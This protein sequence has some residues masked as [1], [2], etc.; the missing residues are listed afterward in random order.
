M[1]DINLLNNFFILNGRHNLFSNDLHLFVDRHLYVLDDFNFNDSLLN[2]RYIHLLDDFFNF[3]DFNNPINNPFD[4]LWNL[5]YLLNNSRYYNNF[6][7]NF[8]N[9]NNFRHFD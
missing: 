3:L 4:N 7:D 8:F 6:F 1:I 9:L 2:N 5:D